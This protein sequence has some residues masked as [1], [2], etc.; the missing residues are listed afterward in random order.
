M[1][2]PHRPVQTLEVPISG[3]AISLGALLKLAHVV[4]SGG[5]AKALIQQG[6]VR[7]NGAVETRRRHAVVPGDVVELAGGP[8]LRVTAGGRPE[9]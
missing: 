8:R 7:I 3:G 6:Q 9:P 4:Q 5:E 1:S 2:D